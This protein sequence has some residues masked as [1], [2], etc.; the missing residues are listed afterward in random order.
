MTPFGLP[1]KTLQKLQSVFAQYPEI[2]EVILYGSRAKG[3]Y[4]AG[5]DID[6]TIVSSTLSHQQLLKIENQIDDLLLPYSVDLCLFRTIDNSALI[7]HIQ[8]V[9]IRLSLLP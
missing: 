8:R 3:N 1:T 5:S 4:K 7:E 2:T 9:G 6:L